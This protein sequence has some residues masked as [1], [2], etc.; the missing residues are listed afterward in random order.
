M[1]LC[2]FSKLNGSSIF[3]SSHKQCHIVLGLC[4]ELQLSLIQL[5]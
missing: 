5:N 2:F 4:L 1:L 3:F